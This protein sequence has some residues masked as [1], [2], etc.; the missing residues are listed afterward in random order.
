MITGVAGLR[1]GWAVLPSLLVAACHSNPAPPAVDAHPASAVQTPRSSPP[2]PSASQVE[3]PGPA[4]SEAPVA[5]DLRE[6]FP[7]VKADAKARIVQFDGIVPIDAHDKVTPLVFL[8]V[9]ACTQDTKE[10][11]SLVMTQARPSHVHAALLLINLQ[12]GTPG[13]WKVENGELV[14]IDPT[15]DPVDITIS[16]RDATG[17]DVS[18]SP[19]DMIV[20]TNTGARFD[21]G[22]APK[23]AGWLFAGSQIVHRQGREWYDADG[24]GTLIGLTTFGSEAIAYGRVISP[25][26]GVQEPQWIAN[27]QNVPAAGTSVTVT[28]KPRGAPR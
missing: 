21:A 8:E 28:I 25:D 18:L 24:A 26:A 2:E 9:V 27:K 6:V 12:P 3:I 17:R 4:P 13:R 14:A 16:F 15:G 22:P 11:E 1:R 20:D 7:H 19:A 23:P 10:H 5:S